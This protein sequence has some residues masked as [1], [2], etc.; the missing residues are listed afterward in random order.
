M[1]QD[2]VEE[3]LCLFVDD[4]VVDQ[5]TVGHHCVE[6]VASGWGSREGKVSKSLD[7]PKKSKRDEDSVPS[8][9]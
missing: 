8:S 9:K 4:C 6:P 3:L 1:V 7:V 2:V 5:D